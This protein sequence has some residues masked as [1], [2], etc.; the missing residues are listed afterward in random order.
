MTGTGE[1]PGPLREDIT[2]FREYSRLVTSST[3]A[4]NRN[5]PHIQQDARPASSRQ[6]HRIG[7]GYAALHPA[8]QEVNALLAIHSRLQERQPQQH[9]S[10]C[11]HRGLYLAENALWCA[12]RMALATYMPGSSND[13]NDEPEHKTKSRFEHSLTALWTRTGKIQTQGAVTAAFCKE[14]MLNNEGTHVVP[15]TACCMTGLGGGRLRTL[16]SPGFFDNLS[17]LYSLYS[18]LGAAL[19]VPDAA[20]FPHTSLLRLQ[21]SFSALPR[22]TPAVP[23]TAGPACL[24]STLCKG[25]RRILDGKTSQGQRIADRTEQRAQPWE[26]AAL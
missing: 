23:E 26:Q 8:H 16:A 20:N 25:Y 4:S 24:N 2:L 15:V 12:H 10:K 18:N 9:Q 13:S 14:T 7:R 19:E 11:I 21:A 6:R 1:E 3:P 22:S 17:N 5:P